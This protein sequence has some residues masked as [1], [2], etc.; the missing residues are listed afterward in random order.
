[1]V[2]HAFNLDNI[3]DSVFDAFMSLPENMVGEI[4]AGELHTMPRP[5]PRHSRAGSALGFSVGGPFDVGING[6]GG[7]WILDEPELHI[8][9]DIVVPDLAGWRRERMPTLPETAWFEAVPD[10]ACE[11]LSPRTARHD[12]VVKMP[13]YAHWGV[14][15]LWLVDP[16]LRVL[17][18]YEL[19]AGKWVL[20]KALQEDDEVQL[21][22]FDAAGFSLATLWG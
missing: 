3:D 22:P 8:E 5:A 15:H 20:L 21:P 17:E 13:L 4:I 14:R 1:M 2:A 12:R 18:A 9:G 11:I 16:D 10:W 7:W 19:S 6:P